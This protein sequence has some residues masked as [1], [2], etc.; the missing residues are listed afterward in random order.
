V[1]AMT[2]RAYAGLAAAVAVL[3][4]G[5][6]SG[7]TSSRPASSAS[8]PAPVPDQTIAATGVVSSRQPG[9]TTAVQPAP[10][11]PATATAMTTVT[12]TVS[13]FG[14]DANP[15]GVAITAG[16]RW[17][18]AS[19][20][21][22]LDVLQLPS[23]RPARLIR[24]IAMPEP[25]AGMALTPDGRLL[26]LAGGSGAVVV[27]VPAA[28]LGS[29]RA[30][31]G[32]LSATVGPR[33]AGAVEVAVSRD[34]RYAFV[35]L[36]DAAQV[37]VFDLAKALADHFLGAYL[38]A[39]PTQLAPVGLAVSP[40]GRWLYSTSELANSHT[41]VG[42]LNVISVR[43]AESDPPTSVVATAPAGCNPVR[44]VTSAGGSVIW[45][46]ARASDALLAFSA[47]KL[48]TD[49]GHSLLAD[50][51]VGEAPVGLA[52]ARDD[53]LVVVADSDRFGAPGHAASLAVVSVADALASR[54]ALVG[55]LPAGQ[56]PRDMAA[57][58]G[59]STVL[60]ANFSSDQLEVVN[61][62][63]LP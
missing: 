24:T 56:F 46:T 62:A 43:R 2:R 21:G 45:V 9:C 3:V 10:A 28:E 36:E 14:A 47:A 35:S 18:F 50:V 25:T 51:E 27:S 44:V 26:L 13:S 52:L 33:P 32:E 15:F 19:V 63:A 23:G 38:G 12:R 22:D 57:G 6:A 31:L 11:L 49:R 42:T 7:G 16:G 20:G 60:V 4:T 29:G 55:Y 40:D 8:P 37:A 34:S 17:A 59:G 61:A 5:C 41:E 48:R 58:Q 1:V 39:I 53:S 54:P 30:V